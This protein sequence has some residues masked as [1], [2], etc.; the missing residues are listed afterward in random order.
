MKLGRNVECF[1]ALGPEALE[2]GLQL[3]VDAIYQ[4]CEDEQAVAVSFNMT[5]LAMP[6]GDIIVTLIYDIALRAQI[7]GQGKIHRA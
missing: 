7:P 4:F 5:Q 2:S 3:A 1:K 6:N